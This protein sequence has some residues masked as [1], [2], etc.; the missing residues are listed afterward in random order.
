MFLHSRAR[1]EISEDFDLVISTSFWIPAY[2]GMAMQ[3]SFYDAINF[4]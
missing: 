2:A 1:R 3:K 4:Y